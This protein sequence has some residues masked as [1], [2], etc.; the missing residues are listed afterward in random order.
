VS[1][2][3]AHM[4]VPMGGSRYLLHTSIS[5]ADEPAMHYSNRV[6]FRGGKVLANYLYLYLFLN[7]MITLELRSLSDT[8]GVL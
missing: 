2:S 1:V 6:S 3:I 5:P 7:K 8:R 4:R